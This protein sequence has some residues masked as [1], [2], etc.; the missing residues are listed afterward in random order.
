MNDGLCNSFDE[1]LY[2]ILPMS[3][4]AEIKIESNIS[5]STL[6]LVTY[7]L[8]HNKIYISIKEKTRKRQ[9]KSHI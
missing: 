4:F 8:C 2:C 1:F 9:I 6:S 3:T 5:N 7:E